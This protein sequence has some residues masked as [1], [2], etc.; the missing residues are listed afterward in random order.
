MQCIECNQYFSFS[1]GVRARQ[2]GKY[3][4]TIFMCMDCFSKTIG[5]KN[6]GK[7]EFKK[8]S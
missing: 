8:H 4:R 7:T 5:R 3:G 1:K 2:K 6:N